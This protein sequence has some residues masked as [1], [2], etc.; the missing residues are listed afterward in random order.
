MNPNSNNRNVGNEANNV[1]GDVPGKLGTHSKGRKH[2]GPWQTYKRFQTHWHQSSPLSLQTIPLHLTL[3][4]WPN[5]SQVSAGLP[6]LFCHDCCVQGRSGWVPLAYHGPLQGA[7]RGRLR[8]PA[9]RVSHRTKSNLSAG[10]TG[11]STVL[12]KFWPLF[13]TRRE[14]QHR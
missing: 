2:S 10:R 3:A 12:R 4:H 9:R 5:T 7:R 6:V 13:R 8:K 1:G 14:S 11:S